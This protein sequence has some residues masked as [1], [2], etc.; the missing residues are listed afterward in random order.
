[1][2]RIIKRIFPLLLTLVILTSIGWYLFEYDPA[3]TRDIL[4]QHARRLEEKGDHSAAVK[5]Y[6]FAYE[7][8]GG[9]DEVAIEL[10]EKFKE[11]GNYSKAEYTLRKAIADGGTVELYMALSRTYVEQGKLRDAVLMLENASPQMQE[12]LK[13]LRPKA[14]VASVLSG[15]YRE[16]L[17]LELQSDGNKIYVSYDRDY[18]SART[19]AYT[20]PISLDIGETTL[21]ALSVSENGL[22]SPLAVYNYIIYDVVEVVTFVDKTFEQTVRTILGYGPSRVIYSD[23]L[24]AVEEMTLPGNLQTCQDLKWMTN[25]KKLRIEGGILDDASALSACTKLEQLQIIGSSISSDLLKIIGTLENLK[26]LELTENGISSIDP[27]S[28]LKKLEH[29]NLS[30]NAIRDISPLVGLNNLQSLNLSSNALISL[31]GLEAL[32]NLKVLD[33]SFNSIVTTAPLSSMVTLEQLNVSS[34]SLRALDGIEY[35]TQLQILKAAY[36]E[37]VDIELLSHCQALT[38]LDV[39]HNTLLDITICAQLPMLE[40]LD[41]SYNEVSALPDFKKE[42][43]LKVIHGEYNKISSLKKLGGL[44]SLTH[45]YMNYNTEI[46]AISSLAN[47]PSLLEVYVYG[48]RVTKVS[49]LTDKGIL[50]VYSPNP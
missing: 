22:V 34:N 6:N 45:I 27:L 12:Q 43:A 18:P 40:E 7:H 32:T 29:I 19:D 4:L 2:S 21:F 42:C 46:S 38:Y 25:L 48:T 1:M 31:E 5:L 3:F 13:A 15:S 36:N 49:D 16:Y 37:L 26:V 10:A 39:S 20:G 11:I 24:W 44:K 41:F 33:V 23:A 28:N 50:V 17:T 14:P 9:S 35:L 8:T 47:C 30:N